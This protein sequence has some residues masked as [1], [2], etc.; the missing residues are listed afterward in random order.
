MELKKRTPKHQLWGSL[1]FICDGTG[2]SLWL[3]FS[4]LLM[5]VPR[6]FKSLICKDN[7]QVCLSCSLLLFLFIQELTER[8]KRCYLQDMTIVLNSCAT[9]WELT[10]ISYLPGY[11]SDV[12]IECS[13]SRISCSKISAWT[14]FNE[15]KGTI[16]TQE[17]S[18]FSSH[19]TWWKK[20]KSIKRNPILF[21]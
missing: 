4:A 21:Q 17:N 3:F 20:K 5:V 19:I 9:R 2:L 11:W 1:Q 12:L 18:I 7:G 14:K 13:N 10:S 15:R 6:E 16:R 8:D